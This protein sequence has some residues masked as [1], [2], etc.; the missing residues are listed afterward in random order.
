MQNVLEEK[1]R[2]LK[3]KNALDKYNKSLQK[4]VL[5]SRIELENEVNNQKKSNIMESQIY[6]D[7]EINISP[8][9]KNKSVSPISNLT[10]QSK[11]GSIML[12][13]NFDAIKEENDEGTGSNN[14]S[15][16]Q[17]TNE[18]FMENSELVFGGS[19]MGDNDEEEI[20]KKEEKPKIEE[21]PKKEE[22]KNKLKK[23]SVLGMSLNNNIFEFN[24]GYNEVGELKMEINTLYKNRDK[25][26][27]KIKDQNEKLKQS[28]IANE[29]LRKLIEQKN[30]EIEELKKK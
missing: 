23:S 8:K 21:K 19:Y 30:K 26:E 27:D 4:N 6:I 16:K 10:G 3:E 22:K 17:S 18:N 25:M 24:N 11:Y 14:V 5:K 29:Q 7:E 2:I 13:G 9:L 28:T 12:L 15:K 1:E 20:P